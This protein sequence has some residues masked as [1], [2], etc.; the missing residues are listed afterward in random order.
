MIFGDVNLTVDNLVH[1]ESKCDG[2][3]MLSLQVNERKALN[4][5]IFN[6]AQQ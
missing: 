6:N 2:V 3:P 5:F 4:H 1:K